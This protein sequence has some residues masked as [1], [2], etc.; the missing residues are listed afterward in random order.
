M[1][2]ADTAADTDVAVLDLSGLVASAPGADEPA[3]VVFTVVAG[4]QP[5]ALFSNGEAVT[6]TVDTT[7]NTL[8]ATAGG[9]TVF[10]L[11]V[12]S[13][14]QTAT[15]DLNDQLDHAPGSGDDATLDVDLGSWLQASV[16]D[17][18]GDTVVQP[19][20]GLVSVSVENDVPTLAIISEGVSGAVQEDAL[21][22]ATL[23]NTADVDLSVG[24][25]DTA[26][27]TDVAVLDLS[28]LVASAPGADEPAP[29]VFT[30]VAGTQP[31]ALFSIGEAVT[32][33][34]DTTTNTL[35]ATA[36]G[37][38]GFHPGGG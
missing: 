5:A 2:I 30:V 11:A 25:A 36:G 21:G 38:I 8:T 13:A 26:A 18:D 14:A 28:R 34:V 35:T 24:I 20:T 9:R 29:V 16:T 37:R 17:A 32:Y 19:L 27:D 15:F 6:Y 33:T 12:D 10:T 22:S 31:A 23:G 1:G 3:P 7:T 4:T